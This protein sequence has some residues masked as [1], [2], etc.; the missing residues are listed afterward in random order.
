MSKLYIIGALALS[1]ANAYIDA[2]VGTFSTAAHGSAT[3]TVTA[4]CFATGT[5]TTLGLNN[6][7]YQYYQ[8]TLTKG[9]VTYSTSTL[10]TGVT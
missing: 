4:D 3:Y 6:I 2:T 1:Q 7:Y 9:T 10:G 5:A 8:F